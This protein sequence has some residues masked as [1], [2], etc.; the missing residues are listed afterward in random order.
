ML[1]TVFVWVVGSIFCFAW[2]VFSVVCWVSQDAGSEMELGCLWSS[3]LGI[4]TCRSGEGS[5]FK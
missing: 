3:T 5:R 2:I 4:Y 1:K